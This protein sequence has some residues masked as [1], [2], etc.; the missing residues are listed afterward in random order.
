MKPQTTPLAVPLLLIF[1]FIINFQGTSE[2]VIIV[3]CHFR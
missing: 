3:T 1:Q 2:K